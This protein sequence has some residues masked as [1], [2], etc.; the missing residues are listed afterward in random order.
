MEDVIVIGAG[1]AGNN[2]ALR[3]A[4][5]GHRVTVID[6]RPQSEIG[7]KLCTGIISA[8]CAREYPV[9][10]SLV[11]QPAFSATISSPNGHQFHFAGDQAQAYIINRVG[12]VSSIADSAHSAGAN[13]IYGYTVTE[14]QS[15][16]DQVTVTMTKNSRLYKQHAKSVVVASGFGPGLTR[17]LGLDSVS[18]YVTGI[19]VQVETPD[20]REVHVHCGSYLSP[21]FFAWIVPTSNGRALVGLLSRRHA[22]QHL[23]RLLTKLRTDGQITEAISEPKQWGVPL[24]PLAKTYGHRLLVVGDAAGQVKPITGGGIF[25]SLL[26]SDIAA[27]TLH[28]A[29]EYDNFSEEILSDYEHRWKHILQN[30]LDVGYNARKLFEQLSDK[31]INLLMNVAGRTGM[32]HGL[33]KLKSVDFDWHSGSVLKLL[34]HPAISSFLGLIS[35]LWTKLS[36]DSMSK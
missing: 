34:G 7:D 14:I 29:C 30:E 18:D 11:Y 20:V 35:P 3:L 15:S 8:A 21:G 23:E 9:D 2:A 19:Q 12:Y 4:T 22:S 17:P 16:T 27:D 6:R 36:Q 26:A 31:Q 24:R 5:L 33:L 13:F 25:Y 32:L 28:R 10:A 1:P